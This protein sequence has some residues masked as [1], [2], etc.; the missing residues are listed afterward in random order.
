MQLEAKNSK[1][2]RQLFSQIWA[3]LLLIL[4][5]GALLIETLHHHEQDKLSHS[6]TK[7]DQIHQSLHV[8]AT[9]V[10]CKLCEIIKHQFHFYTLLHPVVAVLA[11]PSPMAANFHY[12]FG[13]STA[14]RR[15]AANKGP[16]SKV[17]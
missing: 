12:Q 13:H 10:N 2:N 1:Y 17:A 14:Y 8:D 5:S 7:Y 3:F 9:K 6:Q 4:F 16:P 15:S 11:V